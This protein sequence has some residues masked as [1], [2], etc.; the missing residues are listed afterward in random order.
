M[1]T[2]IVFCTMMATM[3]FAFGP[4]PESTPELASR[5]MVNGACALPTYTNRYDACPYRGDGECDD[6]GPGAEYCVC[7]EG[8]DGQDCGYGDRDGTNFEEAALATAAAAAAATAEALAAATAYAAVAAAM[9]TSDPPEN[10]CCYD[11]YESTGLGDEGYETTV[12]TCGASTIYHPS[13][14][15]AGCLAGTGPCY[16]E[17]HHCCC[18]GG[19]CRNYGSCPRGSQ[20]WSSH[21]ATTCKKKNPNLA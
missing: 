10:C 16:T 2:K 18:Q 21:S 14:A 15:S 20:A 4:N 7:T 17:F 6:G 9:W 1:L 19:G 5:Y 13:H 12:M 3:A 11:G 8:D